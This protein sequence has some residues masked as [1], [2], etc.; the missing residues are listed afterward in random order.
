MKV[1]PEINSLSLDALHTAV[2]ER[3]ELL[4]ISDLTSE[5]IRVVSDAILAEYFPEFGKGVTT[6]LQD[7]L[8]DRMLGFGPLTKLLEDPDTTEIMV[9]G[10]RSLYVEKAGQLLPLKNTFTTE[11]EVLRVMNKIVSRVGRRI[12]TASPTV[13]ARLPDGSRVHAIIAPLSLIGPILTIRRFPKNPPTLAMLLE[14]ETLSPELAEFLTECIQLKKNIVI[15]GGT[16]S[17][18]TTTLNALAGLI[19]SHE[20]LVTIEDSAELKINHPHLVALESRPAN[21]EGKGEVTV[22]ALL[23][24]A[25]RMRPDRIIVGEIRSGEALDMLQ[26]MNTGH[27]GSLTSVHANSPF[28]ALHRIESLALMSDVLLPHRAIRE[29]VR[30]AV[31]I[32]IQQE[33][34]SS[35]QRKITQ[36]CEMTASIGEG[37]EYSLT[38]IFKL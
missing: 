18:K 10:T 1:I 12:D 37:E 33:R 20:R 7:Q 31:N 2:V 32:V 26:A 35:G 8:E 22:R 15:S 28:E 19:P 14:K 29:Q 4:A 36:V 9:N 11:E 6:E 38:Q 5:N 30:A 25:L 27:P 3:F 13:D 24:N 17:G 34:L 23:K 21:L 16:G